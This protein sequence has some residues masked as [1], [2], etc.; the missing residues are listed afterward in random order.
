[1]APT[2]A[3]RTCPAVTIRFLARYQKG[4]P[5]QDPG[6]GW[7][8]G[9]CASPQRNRQHPGQPVAESRGPGMQPMATGASHLRVWLRPVWLLA[10][11]GFGDSARGL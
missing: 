5:A 6:A 3:A 8:H 7:T 10:A 4:G 2:H 11:G 9:S 1:M